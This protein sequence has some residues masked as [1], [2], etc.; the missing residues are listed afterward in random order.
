MS[1]E[2]LYFVELFKREGFIRKK[3]KIC[4]R[5]FWTLREDQEVCGDQPC[6]DYTF[7]L[8]P[9][10]SIRPSSMD[11]VRER[12]L[13]FFE[14]RGH[15]RV[16]RYPVVARWREDV[17]LVGASIYDFQPWVTEGIVPPPANPLVISQPC[18]R[19]TDVDNVGRSGRHLTA[20]EMMAHHAFNIPPM[21]VYWNNE[22]VE[23]CFDFFT[24]E[25]KIPP[26][27]ISF[28]EDWWS[29]GGNAGEDFEVLIRGLEVATLVFMHYRVLDEEK[30]VPMENRIVDTGYGLERIYWLLTGRPTIYDAVFPNFI[31]KLRTRLGFE[32]VS[33]DLLAKITRISG[34]LDLKKMS[35][36]KFRE[37]IAK[38]LGM[39]IDELEKITTPQEL[40][41]TLA[42]HSKSV[43]LML[44]DG[45]VPSN[46]G[47]GYLVRLLIRRMLRAMYS[48]NVEY[49]LTEVVA[50]QIP[51]VATIVPEVKEVE[52]KVLEIVDLEERK[53][54]EVLRR[55]RK[56]VEKL[57]E[58]VVRRGGKELSLDSLIE[59]YDSHG[60]PPEVVTDVASRHGISV[61]IPD[62]FY[63]ILAEK[64]QRAR[65]EERIEDEYTRLSTI[66]KDLPPT[67]QLYYDD[68]YLIEFTARVLKVI[69]G[70]YV[71]LDRTAFYPEGGGQPADV[72]ELVHESGKC[73][74]IDVKLIG[75]IIVHKIEGSA[76]K[77]GEVV[78]G[79]IDY[80]RRRLLMRAHT[81]THIVLAAARAVLGKHVW[82]AGAQKD[83]YIS[84][85]DITHYKHLTHD[86]VK[87][88]EML[89][90]DI[91]LKNLP[92]KT[93]FIEREKA[94][95]KFG[96]TLYQGGVVPARV[97]RV[98]EI[99]GF[100]AQ[101]C[102][103]THCRTTGEVGA[104]KVVKWERVQEG[105]IRLYFTVGPSL[106]RYT[107]EIE[108]KLREIARVLN[109]S[110]DVRTI[111]QS[112]RSLVERL[113]ETSEKL[114]RYYRITR[115]LLLQLLKAS[116][117]HVRGVSCAVCS[118]KNL[119]RDVVNEVLKDFTESTRAL[120]VVLNLLEDRGIIEVYVAANKELCHQLGIDCGDVVTKVV[121]E[122]GGRGG[123]RG[124]Y[125]MGICRSTDL[126][127]VEDKVKEIL[128]EVFRSEKT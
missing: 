99:E 59:L 109:C 64:H 87:K 23:L 94:E 80:T 20:F 102:G 67:Q 29:G 12:F 41:Y 10:P 50:L 5:Y 76:P 1:R 96:F 65:V 16:K 55:G 75:N 91:V 9:P 107:D 112:T 106:V 24:K 14:R 89:A 53:Y 98:V 86:E 33:D 36:R 30:V 52:D 114:S 18:I 74:V 115:D 116:T 3:C 32:R 100:D 127:K 54:R 85:L 11:E 39:E 118:F 73:R 49:P 66:L 119:D 19:L 61:T 78:K 17:Y 125:G 83:P 27:E 22:T 60:I 77:E 84:R 101:A 34:K 81:A 45:V 4:G 47:A 2:E 26:E 62:N 93:Y 113:K 90:N 111:E 108:E 117:S 7:I 25:L 97:I 48:M 43:V 42:D 13:S 21:E 110:P 70:K 38:S 121:K 95:A 28:I 68:P 123:G 56:V 82:Q 92:V 104:I 44:T 58:D 63:T 31:E 126:S 72:G 79:V 105:V 69:D 37:F 71:V 103:G 15:T 40:L 51:H 124:T 46:S 57:I 122:F 88:I 8:N 128:E 35:L 120:A 6:T